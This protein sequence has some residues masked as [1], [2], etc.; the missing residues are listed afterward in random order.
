MNFFRSK[1][2]QVRHFTTYHETVGSLEDMNKSYNT[3]ILGQKKAYGEEFT[4]YAKNQKDEFVGALNGIYD[5]GSEEVRIN[6]ELQSQLIDLPKDL[7]PLLAQETEMS[8][9]RDMCDKAAATAA[10]SR[11]DCEKAEAAYERAKSGGNANAITKTETAFAAAQRKVEMDEASAADQKKSIE[12][13]EEP[14]RAQFLE[15]FVTPMI[16]ALNLKYKAAEKMIALSDSFK[17]AA[18]KMT[19][20][21]DPSVERHKGML[22]DLDKIVIE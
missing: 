6:Q 21:V 2:N 18:E 19:D 9:W 13:K 10:A 8:K 7:A 14:Y 22:E 20:Y 3:L 16:A 15:S 1:V 12:E 4:S 17:E 5:A 11:K